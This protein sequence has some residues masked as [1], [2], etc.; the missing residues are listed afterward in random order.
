MSESQV[1][2]RSSVNITGGT[3]LN[4]RSLV[5][6]FSIT[7]L[8]ITVP[9]YGQQK[10]DC[11]SEKDKI[12]CPISEKDPQ[13]LGPIQV[14]NGSH[15]VIRMTNKSPFDDCT[16]GDVKLEDIKQTNP[17]VTILQLLTK[18][19]T[20]V[21]L[22]QGASNFIQQLS[23]QKADPNVVTS[24]AD[25]LVPDILDM[26]TDLKNEIDASVTTI[27][28]QVGLAKKIDQLFS[29]PPRNPQDFDDKVSPIEKEL[30]NVTSST[31]P[32]LD[33][34][35]IRY[36]IL[37][38]RLK[39]IISKGPVAKSHDLTTIPLAE[40]ALDTLAGQLA[41]L[42]ANYDAISASRTQFKSVLAFLKQTDDVRNSV[43]FNP[44]VKDVPV[45]R[46]TQKTATTSVTCSNTFTKKASTPQIGI[47]VLYENDP[48]LSVSVGPLLSTIEKRKLGTTAVST[49]LNSSG[50]PTFKTIFAVVDQAPVQVVPFAFLNYRIVYF[51]KAPNPTQRP[52]FSIHASLG[53]GVNPNSGTNEVEF[54][55]G[56][57]LGF[58]NL[59]IQ[60]GDHIGRFQQ[61]FK[62]G[63]NIG[64]T[65]PPNFPSTLP[66]NKV[67]RNGFAIALSYKLPL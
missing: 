19:A 2:M 40:K 66:I 33:A 63:F 31:D 51:H 13:A 26:S 35:Q 29:D 24:P 8:L 17:I 67:Y 60:F 22:P 43:K 28:S 5:T 41:A 38:D 50:V 46:G 9:A 34:E 18:S 58:K 7:Y 1:P 62:G 42:K 27:A 30:D 3:M 52:L 59:L 36:G 23:S 48:R 64:D 32:S 57:S 55:A 15:V 6:Y 56:P 21:S 12:V 65:V 16:L 45:L 25:N 14:P 44:F 61:G 4:C 49:G 37:H 39:D 20:G 47:T 10:N 54:F 11:I 53:I